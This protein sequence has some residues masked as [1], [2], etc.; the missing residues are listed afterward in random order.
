MNA[1][2]VLFWIMAT[3][4]TA[5]GFG[6]L[7]SK[8]SVHSALW[9]AL[10]MI[11]L[12]LLY[13][14]QGAAFLGVVQVVVYTGAVMMLFLFVLMIIGVDSAEVLVETLQ[15]QRV[16][17]I[18]AA[19]GFAALLI[20]G[21]A[22]SMPGEPIGL[23]QVDAASGGNVRAIAFS[24]FSDYVVIFELTAALLITATIGALVLAY[25][26]RLG[27]HRTQRD[28]SRDRFRSGEDPGP[29]PAPGT[30]ARHNAVDTPALL[31][32]GSLA[33]NSVPSPMIA[34]GTVRPIDVAAAEEVRQIAEGKDL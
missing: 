26:E 3:T 12:A 28:L 9:L 25:R 21:F 17:A 16:L 29:L 8:K 20:S 6:M 23:A 5:G 11:S 34:R 24:L 33:T 32:D 27:E 7:I 4:A 19:I 10:T 15:G 22:R 14:A 31:P 1:E 18:L 30:Y 2:A 13:V